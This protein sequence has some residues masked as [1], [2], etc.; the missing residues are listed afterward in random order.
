MR[1][2]MIIGVEGFCQMDAFMIPQNPDL[3][4]LHPYFIADVYSFS[5]WCNR[6][7]ISFQKSIKDK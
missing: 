7:N 4:T 6:E 3:G 1:H 5:V 2:L